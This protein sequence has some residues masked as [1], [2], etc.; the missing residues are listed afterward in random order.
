[1]RYDI[2]PVRQAIAESWPDKMDDSCARAEWGWKP[3]VGFESM[4]D[5]MIDA[6][7]KKLNKQ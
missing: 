2:D 1:M 5:I 7:R 4:V 6:L 3:E